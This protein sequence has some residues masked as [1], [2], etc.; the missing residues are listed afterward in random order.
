MLTLHEAET[1]PEPGGEVAAPAGRRRTTTPADGGAGGYY[2]GIVAGLV[3]LVLARAASFL[4]PK[5]VA[6][7]VSADAPADR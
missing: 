5:P 3:I 4:I 6:A 2:G 7:E 1:A